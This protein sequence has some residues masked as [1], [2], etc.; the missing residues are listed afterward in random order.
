MNSTMGLSNELYTEMNMSH[1]FYENFRHLCT[2][3]EKK[4]G[5]RLEKI[6]HLKSTIS[7]NAKEILTLELRIKVLQS[8]LNNYETELKYVR[9]LWYNRLY[10][11]FS[12]LRFRNP[13]YRRGA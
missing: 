4:I 1:H 7:I 11:F 10:L 2:E 13:F 5:D 8:D 3:E 6:N 9:S 12:T